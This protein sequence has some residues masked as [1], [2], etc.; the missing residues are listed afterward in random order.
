MARRFIM[1]VVMVCLSGTLW[2][3]LDIKKMTYSTYEWLFDTVERPICTSS[4]LAGWH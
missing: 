1:M 2:N 3:G 4:R